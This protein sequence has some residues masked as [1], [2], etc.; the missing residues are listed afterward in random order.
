MQCWDATTGLRSAHTLLCSS[1]L[2]LQARACAAQ[3]LR[4]RQANQEATEN[5]RVE[6]PE[7]MSAGNAM[8]QS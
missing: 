5:E 3:A 4:R 1:V 6:E 2:L 8:Q 7:K